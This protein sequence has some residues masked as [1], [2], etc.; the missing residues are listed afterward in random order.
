MG[1]TMG[2]HVRVGLE[3]NIFL[4]RRVLSTIVDLVEK[5]RRIASEFERE[6]ATP[7]DARE[8]LGFKGGDAVNFK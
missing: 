4:R 3:D 7:D 1:I 6:V 5:G 8:M 2:R